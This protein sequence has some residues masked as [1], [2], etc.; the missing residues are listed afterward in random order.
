[1]KLLSSLSRIWVYG[2]QEAKGYYSFL[3]FLE[4]KYAS[5]QFVCKTWMFQFY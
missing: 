4:W 3:T 5:G 2:V 1:M